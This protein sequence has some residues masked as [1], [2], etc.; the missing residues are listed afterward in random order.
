MWKHEILE[1]IMSSDFFWSEVAE[2]TEKANM[3][4]AFCLGLYDLVAQSEVFYF[5]ERDSTLL[6]VAN[7]LKGEGMYLPFKLPYSSTVFEYQHKNSKETDK[8]GWHQYPST[9]RAVIGVSS[10]ECQMFFN[11][12]YMDE[13]KRWAV[14]PVYI[15]AEKQYNWNAYHYSMIPTDS[16]DF[17]TDERAEQQCSELNDEISALVTMLS[18]LNCQNVVTKTVEPPE[19]L[20]RK[21]I[22]GGKLPLY[23]YKILEVV[24]G[25][26]KLKDGGSVPW[27]YKSPESVRFHL[28]RGHFKTFSPDKPLFGKYSGTFWWNPQ[29]RGDRRKG[30]V[31]KEYAVKQ[32]IA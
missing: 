32:E 7:S 20:N 29:S 21:R 4:H 16:Y 5:G 12:N 2:R 26:P 17:Y 8:N 30:V 31:E 28:C 22:R 11:V 14:C 3:M 13:W 6:P 10:E 23:T 18:I 19:K 25:K 1:G 9:K 15:K 24:K 27:D